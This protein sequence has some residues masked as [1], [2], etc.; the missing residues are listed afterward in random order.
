MNRHTANHL[1]TL[2]PEADEFRRLI[3]LQ[4]PVAPTL[5]EDDRQEFLDYVELNT[6]KRITK[7]RLTLERS[8]LELKPKSSF[9]DN[10]TRYV[11]NLSSVTL[12]DTLLEVLSLGP[13][14]CCPHGGIDQIA[15]DTQFENAYNQTLDLTAS[16]THA[17]EQF[18][19]DLAN[20]SYQY[21]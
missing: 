18:K 3:S 21:K 11:H 1:D 19:S 8:L 16:S 9:P 20:C 4:Q 5:S 12:D 7:K 10:P 14:F 2:R 13:K 15:I 17:V 6:S